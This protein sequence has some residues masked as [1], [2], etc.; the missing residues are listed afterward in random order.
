VQRGSKLLL[1]L[2]SQVSDPEAV[3]AVM[4]QHARWIEVFEQVSVDLVVL[5]EGA[6]VSQLL[7]A[8]ATAPCGSPPSS[9]GLATINPALDAEHE[10]LQAGVTGGSFVAQNQEARLSAAEALVPSPLSSGVAA[11]TVQVIGGG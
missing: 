4:Q 10:V 11:S 6:S 9:C 7:Q 5:Q 2:G 1:W 8:L 3:Q